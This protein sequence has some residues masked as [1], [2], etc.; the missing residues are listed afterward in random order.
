[1]NPSDRSFRPLT[2]RRVTVRATALRLSALVAVL[3]A[4]TGCR[5]DALYLGPDVEGPRTLAPH[6][7]ALDVEA[8]DTIEIDEEMM[9]RVRSETQPGR[10]PIQRLGF[11][12]LVRG[13]DGVEHVLSDERE[14][15]EPAEAASAT[16]IVPLAEGVV[17][18]GDVVSIEV[19]GYSVNTAGA[20]VA[21]SGSEFQQLACDVREDGVTTAHEETGDFRTVQ[22]VHGRTIPFASAGWIA[23]LLVHPNG[24]RVFLSN[25]TAHQVEVF[26]VRDMSFAGSVRV[27]SEPWGLETN[28]RGD[29]LMVANSGGTSLSLVALDRLQEDVARRQEIP[30]LKIFEFTPSE[31][32][33]RWLRQEMSFS[34]RPQHLARDSRG[35]FVLSTKATAGGPSGAFRVGEWRDGRFETRLVRTLRAPPGHGQGS[36]GSPTWTITNV[37]SIQ[38]R[39]RETEDSVRIFDG[40]RSTPWLPLEEAVANMENQGSDILADSVAWDY[41]AIELGDTTWVSPSA[42]RQYVAV[43]ESDGLVMLWDAQRGILSHEVEVNDLVR[44][45]GEPIR[46]IR[47]NHDG[48]FGAVRSTENLYFF[49]RG[50]R[51]QGSSAV[52]AEGTGI[53]L[54]PGQQDN[55]TIAFYGT[56]DNAITAVETTH[57]RTVASLPLRGTVTGP[58]VA[59]APLTADNQ[60][61]SC[62]ADLREAD[63]DCVVAR[64]YAVTDAGL[65]VVRVRAGDL[66]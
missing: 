43:G 42:N 53:A 39:E 11:T 61:L 17:R 24:G 16:F 10:S 31:T 47:L 23:D 46:G 65:L 52:G 50:L 6:V 48:S 58:F 1:M 63:A 26:D 41:R 33:P 35:R 51:L 34:D 32:G 55:R 40:R 14:L 30:R 13:A 45:T 5:D 38:Y 54:R 21:A 29:T 19:F 56:G 8:P 22:V 20:C 66:R 28:A 36:A 44:N 18:E 57:Y 2:G 27:G 37:D 9:V 59:E 3:V 60:G 7:V 49:D 12:A 64:V 62:P 25:H 4:A 15:E